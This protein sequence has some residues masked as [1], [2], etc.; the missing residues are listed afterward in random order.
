MLAQ[1]AAFQ[2][3]HCDVYWVVEL[4]DFANRFAVRGVDKLLGRGR[5]GASADSGAES[6]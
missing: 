6:N 5:S 3:P 1:L 4:P 2:N